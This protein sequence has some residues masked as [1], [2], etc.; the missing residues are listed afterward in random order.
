MFAF[1]KAKRSPCRFASI[2]SR[3]ARHTEVRA[4]PRAA[5]YKAHRRRGRPHL[6]IRAVPVQ[7]PVATQMISNPASFRS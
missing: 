5:W 3:R 1:R 2:V 7:L 6:E 4:A